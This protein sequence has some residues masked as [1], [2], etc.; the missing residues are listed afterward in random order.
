MKKNIFPESWK[1]P[2]LGTD[3]IKINKLNGNVGEK[4]F[5]GLP[6]ASHFVWF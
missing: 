3:I 6:D 1:N 5:S 4:V 2:V